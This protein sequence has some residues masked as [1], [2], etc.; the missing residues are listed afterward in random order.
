[1]ADS[2]A[3]YLSWFEQCVYLPVFVQY[4]FCIGR[5]LY[6]LEGD[7]RDYDFLNRESFDV[8][9]RCDSCSNTRPSAGGN[10]KH[11][12][13]EASRVEACL[14]TSWAIFRI[15]GYWSNTKFNSGVVHEALWA[16]N[17]TTSGA[18]HLT[19]KIVENMWRAVKDANKALAARNELLAHRQSELLAETLARCSEYEP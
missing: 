9:F 17:T 13:L 10:P 12:A 8:G 4:L 6:T 2:S 5:W 3:I 7:D 11:W 19:S 16:L 15:T 14:T 1:M 18:A